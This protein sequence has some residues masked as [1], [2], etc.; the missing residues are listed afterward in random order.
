MQRW[1]SRFRADVDNRITNAVFQKFSIKGDGKMTGLSNSYMKPALAAVALL[2]GA[3]FGALPAAADDSSGN[4]QPKVVFPGGA[5]LDGTSD[6]IISKRKHVTYFNPHDENTTCTVIHLYNSTNSDQSVPL[7]TFR[8]DGTKYLSTTVNVPAKGLV[9]IVSDTVSTISA[10][11]QNTVLV[12]F[13]TSSTY[14]KLYLPRGVFAEGY[15]AWNGATDFDPLA[16]VQTL[17]MRFWVKKKK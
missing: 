5:G 12:N 17:P 10:S 15:I 14:G 6:V 7:A 8:L 9:R 1:R 3:A 4:A 13:T 11:W 16:E 2:A